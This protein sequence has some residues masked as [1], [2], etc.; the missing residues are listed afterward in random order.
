MNKKEIIKVIE[1]YAKRCSINNEPGHDF[2]HV[3]RVRK[4]AL[5]LAKT[6]QSDAF[7]VEILALLHDIEDHKLNHG[8]SV[9]SFLDRIDIDA[10]YKEKV[11]SILPYMSFSKYPRLG[12]EFPIE[13]KI[14]IDADR[15]DAIGAIGVA[16]AFSY[17]GVH[18]RKM[19]GSED[20]TIKH[21]DEKLLILDQY[22]YLD[23]SKQIAEKR[24]KYIKDFYD[25]FL[26]EINNEER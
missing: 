26:R 5:K 10:E 11:L 15:L 21:F 14:V 19:Y 23:E 2:D 20:S 4:M 7:L 3:V 6:T 12:D 22:L 16:R 24:M 8:H 18:H 9:K 25:E 17:G 13:G 1:I